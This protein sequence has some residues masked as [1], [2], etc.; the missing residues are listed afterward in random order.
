MFGSPRV[1]IRIILIRTRL[2]IIS[3]IRIRHVSI[4]RRRVIRLGG[5]Q[6]YLK[7]LLQSK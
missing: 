7:V 5:K 3:I 1:S 2:Q 6:V 4:R